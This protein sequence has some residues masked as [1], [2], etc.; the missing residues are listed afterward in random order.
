MK[1][2]QERQVQKTARRGIWTRKVRWAILGTVAGAALLSQQAKAQFYCEMTFVPWIAY[3]ILQFVEGAVVSGFFGPPGGVAPSMMRDLTKQTETFLTGGDDPAAINGMKRGVQNAATNGVEKVTVG[4]PGAGFINAL[5][6]GAINVAVNDTMNIGGLGF[7]DSMMRGRLD[8]FWKDLREALQGVTMQLYGSD[9]NNSRLMSSMQDASGLTA[10]AVVHQGYEMQSRKQN[11]VAEDTCR[12]DTVAHTMG[13]AESYGRNMSNAYAVQASAVGNGTQGTVGALSRGGYSQAMHSSYVTKYCD[14]DDNGGQ[15][16]CAGAPPPLK[17]RGATTSPSKVTGV[18]TLDVVNNP[19]DPQDPS[20]ADKLQALSGLVS[21]ITNE[22]PPPIIPKAALNTSAGKE[23]VAFNRQIAT[24]MDALKG[25]IF[26]VIG[27]RMPAQSDPSN[28]KDN[29]YA[30]EVQSMRQANGVNDAAPV[31]SLRES[32]RAV[33]ENLANPNWY[34]NLG[35]SGGTIAQKELY[36]KAYNTMVLYWLIEKQEK[37]SNA[38]AIE[39]SNM[40]AKYRDRGGQ[41]G[42]MPF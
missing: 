20:T 16:P 8:E 22:K 42:E 23:A 5:V 39:L 9:V 26:S 34:M 13:R 29:A 27:D 21:N 38:Y 1:A 30:S 10:S 36:L 14:P 19:S 24:Q 41:M 33:E 35:D 40:V 7:M 18:D 28:P 31:P 6:G 25:T 15:S 12:F 37:I 3:G 32:L 4:L 17:L 11:L 2:K